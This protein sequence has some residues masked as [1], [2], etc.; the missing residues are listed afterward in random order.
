MATTITDV[1]SNRDICLWPKRSCTSH[2]RLWSHCPSKSNCSFRRLNLKHSYYGSLTRFWHDLVYVAFRQLSAV[3]QIYWTEIACIVIKLITWLACENIL[4]LF[5]IP[6]T[7]PSCTL[8]NFICH[9]VT[10]LMVCY[11]SMCSTGRLSSESYAWDLAAC[12]MLRV[13]PCFLT[14]S[15]NL[16]PQASFVL[17]I[18]CIDRWYGSMKF[19]VDEILSMI[20]CN[21]DTNLNIAT[22]LATTLWFHK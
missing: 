21:H 12:S 22:V 13:F 17:L 16:H 10:V 7:E 18:S 2:T 1:M 9:V 15:W 11:T 20:F 14:F 4:R 3:P 19:E 6:L 5:I 8:V